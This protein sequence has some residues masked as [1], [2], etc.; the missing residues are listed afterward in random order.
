MKHKYKYIIRITLKLNRLAIKILI[1]IRSTSVG[2]DGLSKT[3]QLLANIFR[4]K[5]V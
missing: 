2:K 5:I 4:E 3:Q 1:K